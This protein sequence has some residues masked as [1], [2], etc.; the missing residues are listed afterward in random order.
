M[1]MFF[2]VKAMRNGRK[3]SQCCG[4]VSRFSVIRPVVEWRCR[5]GRQQSKHG[6]ARRPGLDRFAR[7]IRDAGLVAVHSEDEG[8]DRVKTS[9]AMP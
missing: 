8:C 6:K 5:V 7:S 1:V 3:S 9:S 4:R 2:G